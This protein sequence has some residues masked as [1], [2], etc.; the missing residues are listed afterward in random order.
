MNRIILSTCFLLTVVSANAQ[1]SY[2]RITTNTDSADYFLQKGLVEKQNGR[3]L[4]SLKNFE[5]AAKYD[6]TSKTITAELASAYLD[7]HRYGQ[8]REMYKK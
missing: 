5:K 4:E 3:R 6:S 1:T 7:L 2:N 8:A